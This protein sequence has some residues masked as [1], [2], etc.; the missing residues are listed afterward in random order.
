MDMVRFSPDAPPVLLIVDDTSANLGVIASH[1]EDNGFDIVIAQSG[2]DGI[3]RAQRTLP[4]L[5]LLDV[6]MPGIDGF[7]T[8]RRLKAMPETADIPVIF[9]TALSDTS[10]KVTGFEAGGVDYVTKPIQIAEAL[11][12]INTHL[13]LR[14]VRREL[15]QRN[16]ALQDVIETRRKTELALKGANKQLATTI[17]TLEKAQTQLVLSAK[18]A[19]LGALVS[20]IA[21][22]L[23]T[24][25]GT[26]MLTASTLQEDLHKIQALSPSVANNPTQTDDLVQRLQNV[27]EGMAILGRS[28]NRAGELIRKF[29]LV[30]VDQMSNQS[31]NFE[32]D[33]LVR[34]SV[35]TFQAQTPQKPRPVEVCVGPSITVNGY[36]NALEQV[37]TQ[38]LSNAFNHAFDA[39]GVGTV[40]IVGAALDDDWVKLTVSDD[41]KGIAPDRIGKIFDPFYTTRLGQGGSGFGLYAVYNQINY[42][43]GG[44]IHVDSTPG[45]GTRIT[46]KLPRNTAPVGHPV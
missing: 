25:I 7:E 34:E 15:A 23:N 14:A 30:A 6:M 1:L 16:A 27:D 33:Q 11:V 32:L 3:R 39:K 40:R 10:D 4:D 2:E 43:M 31:Q 26:A 22:E 29:R 35:L 18:L 36:P 44:R 19:G 28:L 45:Q 38:L 9:M 37:L 12:R 42:L 21:H 8:C 24:P 13:G 20:G 17:A 5:I 41:G 46:M